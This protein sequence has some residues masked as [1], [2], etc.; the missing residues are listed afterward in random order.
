MVPR[1]RAGEPVNT[2]E[3]IRFP[4]APPSSGAFVRSLVGEVGVCG[5]RLKGV[6]EGSPGGLQGVP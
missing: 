6:S 1:A 4:F 2:S 3:R 5:G